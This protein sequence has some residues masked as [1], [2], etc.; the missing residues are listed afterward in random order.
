MLNNFIYAKSKAMFEE[1]IAEVPNEAIVFIEDTKEIW[2]HGQYFA[3]E[4]IDP[5]AFDNLQTEVSQMKA[6]KQDALI[7]GTN[8]K[9]INGNNIL[10]K[11]NIDISGYDDTELREEIAAVQPMISVT[12]SELKEMRDNAT[13]KPG[14][15]YRIIDYVTTTVQ[16]KTH[17]AGHPFGVIVTADSESTL[18]EE[19][20]A[21]IHEGDTYF[22]DAGAKLEAWK[23]WYCLDNDTERFAWADAENGKGVIY[24]M[25]DEWNN[26]CPYDFKNIQFARWELSNPVGYR[27]YY[28]EEN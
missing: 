7:S 3:G 23:I 4:G 5:V 14:Q 10:G 17:S 27:N 11:G 12:W 15:Q 6:D 1:R 18:N 21:C 22:S 20:R 9:T 16:E 24:R 25:I 19:A 2:N 13:L 26:D 8:I 28:D